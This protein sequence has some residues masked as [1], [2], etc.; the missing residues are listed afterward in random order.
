MHFLI[1]LFLHDVVDFVYSLLHDCEIS[2]QDKVPS[3]NEIVNNKNFESQY[4]TIR[5]DIGPPNPF[6]FHTKPPLA[7]PYAFSRIPRPR[8]DH[9]RIHLKHEI[10]NTWLFMNSFSSGYVKTL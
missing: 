9:P 6:K 3:Q 10:Q 8:W 4:S 7:G 1:V 2:G 5:T